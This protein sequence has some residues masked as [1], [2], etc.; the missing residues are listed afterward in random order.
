M[1]DGSCQEK[2]KKAAARQSQRL[3]LREQRK[4]SVCGLAVERWRSKSRRS[5]SHR[6]IEH[7]NTVCD[8]DNAQQPDALCTDEALSAA[9]PGAADDDLLPGTQGGS[10]RTTSSGNLLFKSAFLSA[11]IW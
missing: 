7:Q 3:R 1:A 9:G 11:R 4:V 5:S 8:A 2:R 6:L 10:T